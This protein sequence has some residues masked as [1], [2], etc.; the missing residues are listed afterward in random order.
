MS[1]TPSVFS[2]NTGNDNTSLHPLVPCPDE[3]TPVYFAIHNGNVYVNA[4]LPNE[5]FGDDVF[6]FDHIY[7]ILADNNA[8]SISC[9][10]P[11]EQRV[12]EH[13]YV[14]DFVPIRFVIMALKERP[15]ARKMHD[16]LNNCLL[17]VVPYLPGTP[18]VTVT[19][20]DTEKA[21]EMRHGKRV[22]MTFMPTDPKT[23]ITDL[24]SIRRGRKL[25]HLQHDGNGGVQVTLH[26]MNEVWKVT[27][28]NFWAQYNKYAVD[29]PKSSIRVKTATSYDTLNSVDI[30]SMLETLDRIIERSRVRRLRGEHEHAREWLLTAYETLK[31]GLSDEDAA[32]LP[33]LRADFPSDVESSEDTAAEVVAEDAV[34]EPEPVVVV[35]EDVPEEK[36]EEAT[37]EDAPETPADKLLPAVDKVQQKTA[38]AFERIIEASRKLHAPIDTEIQSPVEA[39]RQELLEVIDHISSA[40]FAATAQEIPTDVHSKLT[41]LLTNAHLALKDVN[42]I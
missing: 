6:P 19:K 15:E 24:S 14:E 34:E 18:P 5:A 2:F 1:Q 33:D 32:K 28:Q 27:H 8:R 17:E 3:S 38:E 7:Q 29:A 20:G 26:N 21:R 39:L 35:K 10:I 23:P 25:V 4:S 30:R 16:W 13:N 22:V 41:K 9:E 42:S 11:E 37:A 40:C 36:V 12:G 31:A